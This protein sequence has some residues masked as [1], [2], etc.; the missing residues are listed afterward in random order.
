MLVSFRQLQNSLAKA[1]QAVEQTQAE[2]R[3]KDAEISQDQQQ[4]RLNM[5]SAS[6]CKDKI[7]RL[8]FVSRR[9]INPVCCCLMPKQNSIGACNRGEVSFVLAYYM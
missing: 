4:E 6:S 5:A 9:R 3:A 1:R 2:I 7:A 8:S